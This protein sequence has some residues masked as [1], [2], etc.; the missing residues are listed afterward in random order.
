MWTYLDTQSPFPPYMPKP[1]LPFPPMERAKEETLTLAYRIKL[2]V[3]RVKS[4]MLGMLC[5]YFAR[6]QHQALDFLDGIVAQEGKLVL[7]GKSQAGEGE[8]KQRVRYR[9]ANDY[10]RAKK[11]A[12]ALKKQLKLP[13]LHAELCDAAEVQ[14][15]RKATEFDL[16]IHIEGLSRDCQLYLPAKKHRALN[17]A[18]EHPG[19]IL[20][21]SAQIMRRKG[22]W[23]A[24]VYVRCPLPEPYEPQGWYGNDVGVRASVT[25]SDGYRGPDLR[26]I[27]RKQKEKTAE[28]QRQRM[29][30]DF[31]RQTP[32]RQALAR[33]AR[34]LVSVALA[35][36]RGIALEDPKRLPRLRQWAARYF[37][38]RVVLLAAL[39]G[40]Q[41]T[42]IAPPYTS[43]TCSKCGSVETFRYRSCFRCR[44]CGFT[45]NADF[46][47]ACNIRSRACH[48]GGSHLSSKSLPPVAGAKA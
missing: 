10:R 7:K 3:T 2:D 1:P 6:E 46:N 20:G 14:E 48:Y 40:V 9:A 27:L 31:G 21:K 39:V 38:K 47:A 19:A 41:V 44:R 43:L 34:K 35:T 26:P 28:R 16:W 25:R 23:Y 33:E 30:H 18:L 8:F 37:A 45:H 15:P 22:K 32:Q 5:A 13:Y 17:R 11:A 24:I 29:P 42:L 12:K 4:D 36:G